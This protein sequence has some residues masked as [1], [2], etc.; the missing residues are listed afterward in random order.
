LTAR[1]TALFLRLSL[2]CSPWWACG[3]SGA[4][5]PKTTGLL[6]LVDTTS[7]NYLIP[8]HEKQMV[9]METAVYSLRYKHQSEEKNK[10]KEKEKKYQKHTI[11]IRFEILT[12]KGT[13]LQ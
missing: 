9:G 8:E 10:E 1:S 4:A 5:L 12:C 7:P 2:P 3:S 6:W 13:I 11:S